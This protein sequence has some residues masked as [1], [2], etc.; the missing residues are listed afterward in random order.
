LQSIM[1]YFTEP[2]TGNIKDICKDLV[3]LTSSTAV[4]FL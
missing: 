2:E 3:F 4:L 1:L